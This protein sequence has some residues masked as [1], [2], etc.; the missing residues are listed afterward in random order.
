MKKINSTSSTSMK[1]ITLI[2]GS[3]RRRERRFRFMSGPGGAVVRCEIAREE[4]AALIE[5]IDE[6]HGLF[7][8]ADH[9]ALDLAA[10]IPVSDQ[11]GNRHGESRRGGDQCLA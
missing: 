3:S 4:V 2:S 9:Q 7:F 11:R 10:Q 6:L 1:L 5:R 8:H